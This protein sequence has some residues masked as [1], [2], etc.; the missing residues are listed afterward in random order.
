MS[1]ENHKPDSPAAGL[2]PL[3]R[4]GDT[5]DK[6]PMNRIVV[7]LLLQV[8]CQVIARLAFSNDESGEMTS[9]VFL[10]VSVAAVFLFGIIAGCFYW[11]EKKKR[12]QWFIGAFLSLVLGFGMCTMS[13][14]GFH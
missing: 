9:L 2:A 4:Q 7:M 5:Q 3:N 14:L 6:Q 1:D 11:D 13:V 10:M 12:S 8:L